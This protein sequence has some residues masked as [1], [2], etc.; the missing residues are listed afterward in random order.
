MPAAFVYTLAAGAWAS[1]SIFVSTV[2]KP[3][4]IDGRSD[5]YSLG[6]VGF[7]LLTAAPP[8]SGNT[9]VEVCGHHLHTP[10]V[11]PS[12]RAAQ[13]I[14][15]ELD[16]LIA[17]LLAKDPGDRPNS[18]E[19]LHAVLST[20]AARHAWSREARTEWWSRVLAQRNRPDRPRTSG[21]PVGS[22]QTVAVELLGRR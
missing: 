7:F 2:A 3:D 18:A 21:T 9:I 11:P 4:S 19:A 6:A 8:F 5:L 22:S 12:Q 13:A 15:D 16:Q 17:R 14:P 1:A 20:L 10:P